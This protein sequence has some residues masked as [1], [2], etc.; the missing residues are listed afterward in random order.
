MKGENVDLMYP[1]KGRIY[2]EGM[3][4]PEMKAVREIWGLMGF[5]RQTVLENVIIFDFDW[6]K[7]L[8][9]L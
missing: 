7:I 2:T 3:D 8:K 4:S 5:W 9:A 1:T 6:I